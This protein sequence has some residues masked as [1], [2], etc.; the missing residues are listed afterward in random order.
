MTT[1]YLLCGEVWHLSR[2]IDF[3]FF[4]VLSL[5]NSYRFLIGRLYYSSLSNVDGNTVYKF[6]N[7]VQMRFICLEIN[8]QVLILS[9]ACET[10]GLG[11]SKIFNTSRPNIFAKLVH[12]KSC[13][14]GLNSMII[15]PVAFTF[16]T[17]QILAVDLGFGG[18]VAIFL[19]GSYQN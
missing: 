19:L 8:I 7:I 2:A 12:N 17:C 18:L 9:I 16:N 6:R 3:P 10:S 15:V 4:P 11:S 1:E 13:S 14:L 5:G